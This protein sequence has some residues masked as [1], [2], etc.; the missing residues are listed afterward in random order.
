MSQPDKPSL[1]PLEPL[2]TSSQVA[3]H[4]APSLR[5]PAMLQPQFTFANDS[6]KRRRSG[7]TLIEL[8]IAISI[9][10]IISAILVPQ[11]RLASADRNVREASRAVAS[12]FA[13]ASQ[14]AIND[15]EAGVVIE[16]NPNIFDGTTYY[17]GTSMFILRKVPRYTGADDDD[18]AERVRLESL[19]FSDDPNDPMVHA[20]D[21]FMPLPLEQEDLQIIRVDDQISFNV[22]PNIR[23]IID[24]V[25]PEMDPVDEI[26]KLRLRLKSASPGFLIFDDIFP[27]PEVTEQ[28][29]PAGGPGDGKSQKKIGSYTIYRQP[30]KLVS[31]RIDMPTGY[32]VDLRVSG[33]VDGGSGTAFFGLDDRDPA[34]VIDDELVASSI[35]YLF[36]SRGSIDRY[37]YTIPDGGGGYV[38]SVRLPTQ[39]AYLMVREYS[40]DDETIAAVMTSERNMWVTVDPVIGA[41]NVVPGVPVELGAFGSTQQALQAARTLIS[42]GQ[43][44]AQ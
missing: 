30:R 3:P 33:E 14:R 25:T 28:K 7:M 6:R 23:F 43:Q 31:S 15:G 2:T 42:Q 11:L 36:N 16:R 38:R 29:D 19:E 41:A 22:Q 10:V 1:S 37:F 5:D 26:L 17:A 32:L 44:A 20:T 12:L 35:N 8:L 40:T 34:T 27:D 24:M 39:P 9:L 13:Q 18:F 4:L 21:I